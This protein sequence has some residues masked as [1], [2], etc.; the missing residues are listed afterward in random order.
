MQAARKHAI[1]YKQ[2]IQQGNLNTK[3]VVE[4]HS[5][6]HFETEI[7]MEVNPSPY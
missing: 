1:Q 6:C 2:A 3:H 5:P 4:W 7:I